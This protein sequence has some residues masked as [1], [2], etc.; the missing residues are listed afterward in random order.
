V[1]SAGSPGAKFGPGEQLPQPECTQKLTTHEQALPPPMIRIVE[2][3]QRPFVVRRALFESENRSL[4]RQ[5]EAGADV[6]GFGRIEGR[7]HRFETGLRPASPGA[8]SND[9]A[10][11]G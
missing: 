2:L 4:Q 5:A 10:T 6:K 7:L 9:E 1:I 3:A 11:S 8:D